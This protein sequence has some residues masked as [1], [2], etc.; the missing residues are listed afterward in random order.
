MAEDNIIEY[1]R[2]VAWDGCPFCA[3]AYDFL[4]SRGKEVHV[5]YHDRDSKEL[6]EAK[7]AHGWNTVPMITH[8]RVAGDDVSETFI[9]GF[10][11]LRKAFDGFGGGLG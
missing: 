5:V 1:Y 6:Q 2:M 11:D 4:R 7:V 3:G 8:V 9:G 10:D